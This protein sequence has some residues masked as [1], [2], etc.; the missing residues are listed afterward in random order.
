MIISYVQRVTHITLSAVSATL[1]I[2]RVCTFVPIPPGA[3]VLHRMSW[4]DE[5]ALYYEWE[6]QIGAD[7]S[8]VFD[9]EP[10]FVIRPD[11]LFG[12][13]EHVDYFHGVMYGRVM[14]QMADDE[15]DF[16]S[17]DVISTLRGPV[18]IAVREVQRAFRRKRYVAWYR[19]TG[20]NIFVTDVKAWI[21]SK[22][23]YFRKRKHDPFGESV[24][25]T[26]GYVPAPAVAEWRAVIVPA[27][28]AGRR[29]TTN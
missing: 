1:G 12:K 14:G 11:D 28:G 13:I 3:M 17:A 2:S 29:A 6:A 20:W 23:R 8:L 10:V 16:C 4:P 9:D 15:R 26:W 18:F 22:G 7:N 5:Q 27:M 24:A 21:E 19:Q 25:R